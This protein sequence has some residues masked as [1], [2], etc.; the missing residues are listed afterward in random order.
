[1]PKKFR[2]KTTRFAKTKTRK[3]SKGNYP[4]K[5][6]L[7][8]SVIGLLSLF[9]IAFIYSFSQKYNRN[10]VSMNTIQMTFPAYPEQAKL[11]SEIFDENPVLD[12]EIEVRNGCGENGLA[13]E[14]SN[15]LRSN[16]FDVIRSEDADHFGYAKTLLI[17]RNENYEAIK[18][19]SSFL[20]F[21][22]EDNSRVLIQPD[23]SVGADLTLILGKDYLSINPISEFLKSQF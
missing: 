7:M 1:M 4:F 10:G 16:Q 11:A 5:N 19:V 17:S 12:I 13:V 8:N 2:R 23:E 18:L 22:I 6:A 9:L 14:I 20:G 21:D 3:N 15:F